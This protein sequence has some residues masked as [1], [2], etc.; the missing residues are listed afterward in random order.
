MNLDVVYLDRNITYSR[1][2]VQRS[3]LVMWISCNTAACSPV[4]CICL[5]YHVWSHFVKRCR[6]ATFVQKTKAGL[7]QEAARWVGSELTAGRGTFARRAEA[8]PL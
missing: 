4:Y 7:C 8:R 3:T 1:V 5:S 6:K 2:T